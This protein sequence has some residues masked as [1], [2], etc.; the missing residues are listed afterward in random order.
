MIRQEAREADRRRGSATSAALYVQRVT[1]IIR[2]D[3]YNIWG[4]SGIGFLGRLLIHY[5]NI[6]FCDA[7]AP[8]A[9]GEEAKEDFDLQLEDFDEE[10]R[11]LSEWRHSVLGLPGAGKDRP[12]HGDGLEVSGL[13]VFRRSS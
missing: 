5:I 10:V 12:A 6:H 11:V 3:I 8:I 4:N 2:Y 1:E 7:S 9:R 13:D